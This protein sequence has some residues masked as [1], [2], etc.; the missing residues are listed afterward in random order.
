MDSL[1]NRAAYKYYF[2]GQLLRRLK[3]GELPKITLVGALPFPLT[4]GERLVYRFKDVGYSN[5]ITESNYVGGSRGVNVRV[6][7]GV[8]CR[9][10]S[11]RG[12]VEYNDHSNF[13]GNGSLFVTTK[14]L[15]FVGRES[16]VK[17][18]FSRIAGFRPTQGGFAFVRT[19]ASAKREHFRFN[20]PWF[21]YNLIS[22]VSSTEY[23]IRNR[24]DTS[25]DN[26]TG[27]CAVRRL[28]VRRYDLSERTD[29][30][31]D[32]Y[33]KQV[34]DVSC[35]LVSVLKE[36]EEL[37]DFMRLL[38]QL[39]GW[40]SVDSMSISCAINPRLAV[41]AFDDIRKCYENMG[42]TL[43]EIDNQEG[44]GLALVTFQVFQTEVKVNDLLDDDKREYWREYVSEAMRTFFDSV[45]LAT[46]K[47]ELSLQGML[48]RSRQDAALKR[49]SEVL[50]KWAYLVAGC[51]GNVSEG[52]RAWLDKIL[53]F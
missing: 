21:G 45:S 14:N 36:I 46:D 10:G 1:K 44:L 19:S 2:E 29:S 12:H 38:S 25:L 40:E 9:V 11:F 8:Y 17:I 48:L 43:S 20:D 53:G 15:F 16:V 4:K 22:V 5:T 6:C 24:E 52:E 23:G 28:S 7:K 30:Q 18:P 35:D 3:Q 31:C 37:P 39:E 51:D 26:G 33:E 49:Y 34:L 32:D 50:Y 41:L 47:T 42:H 13:V 27:R